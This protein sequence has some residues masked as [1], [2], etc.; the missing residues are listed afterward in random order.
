[1][2]GHA[3]TIREPALLRARSQLSHFATTSADSAVRCDR[4]GKPLNRWDEKCDYQP[5][6]AHLLA[7]DVLALVAENQRL[8][9]ALAKIAAAPM[10]FHPVAGYQFDVDV[11]KI[12]RAALAGTPS[13]DTNVG[14][15]ALKRPPDVTTGVGTPSEDT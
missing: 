1:M 9:D 2:S 7:E 11:G 3:D 5:T 8:R 4:C 13:E 15:P 10:R 6:A 14:V 12:A